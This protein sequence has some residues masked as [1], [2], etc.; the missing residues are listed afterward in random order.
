MEILKNSNNIKKYSKKKHYKK[1]QLKE[2]GRLKELTQGGQFSFPADNN[3][4]LDHLFLMS[5]EIQ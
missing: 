1:P 4:S 2:F 3:C 5:Q